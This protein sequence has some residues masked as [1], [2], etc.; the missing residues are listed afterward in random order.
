[1]AKRIVT[2]L[3]LVAVPG[4]LIFGAVH[5]TEAVMAAQRQEAGVAETQASGQHGGGAHGGG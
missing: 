2:L 5:R 3:V 1:M 4:L